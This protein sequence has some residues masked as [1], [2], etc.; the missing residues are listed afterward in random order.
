MSEPLAPAVF[1]TLPVSGEAG[2]VCVF[3][4]GVCRLVSAI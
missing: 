4:E 2:C 3:E 1:R